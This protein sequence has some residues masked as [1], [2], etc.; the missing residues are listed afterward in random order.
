MLG[1]LKYVLETS[2]SMSPNT[3]PETR[4]DVGE[5]AQVEDHGNGEPDLEMDVSHLPEGN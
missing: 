5:P 3:T 2:A 4:R 1:C